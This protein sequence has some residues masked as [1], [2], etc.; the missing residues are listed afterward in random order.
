M[1][2]WQPAP[3]AS[4]LGSLQGKPLGP[5]RL[6][7]LQGAVNPYGAVYFKMELVDREGNTG[8]P[9]ALLG[10]FSHGPYPAYNWVEV[11]DF[12]S[13]VAFPGGT[14][15][16]GEESVYHQLFQYLADLVPPG[17]HLMVEYEGP[18]WTATREA[19][20]RGIPPL[21]TP[22]G[23]LLQEIGCAERVRDWAI[24]E[25]GR[26]GP[27]KLIGYK[28]FSPQASQQRQEE[29]LQ[30]LRDFLARPPIPGQEEARLKAL[31][32]LKRDRRR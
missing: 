14:L 17:G 7:V 1:S 20:A 21:L 28:A 2:P 22:L 30:E 29:R 16:L 13:Q 10:L 3:A 31:E 18:F 4:S 11:M 32:L 25:G 24:A 27:R 8:V 9:P 6:E 12:Q 15:D 26:E 5:C 23:Q 19:L